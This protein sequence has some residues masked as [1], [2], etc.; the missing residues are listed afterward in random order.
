MAKRKLSSEQRVA[1][2]LELKAGLAGKKKQA[3]ILRAIA[4]KYGITTITARW[5]LKS[6][7]GHKKGRKPGRRGPGRPPGSGNVD[8]LVKLVEEQSR[9]AKA[10]RRLVPRWQTLM[11]REASLKR[12]AAKVDRQLAATS[13]KATTLRKRLDALVR[14]A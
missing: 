12:L 8:G 6:L 9:N 14:G 11:S 10:A 4:E 7:D 3:D 1:L 5:Y 2:R 13:R